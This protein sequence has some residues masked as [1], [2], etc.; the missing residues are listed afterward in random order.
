MVPDL[1]GRI[2]RANAEHHLAATPDTCV[3][4]YIDRDTPAVLEVESG[5]IIEIEAVTHHAGDA[6]DLLMDDGIRAIWSGIADVDRGPGVH[7]MTGPIAVRGARPGDTLLVRI[8]DMWPRLPYG[9][10][11]AANWGLLYNEFAKER[12]TIYGLVDDDSVASG[13][14]GSVAEPM[15]GYDF[16]TRPL[17]DIPGVVTPPDPASRQP[18]SR[19]VRVPVRPHFGVMGVAPAEPGRHSSIPPG[20]FG[21]NVDNWRIGTGTTVCYPV[22]AE[23]AM[24]YVGDPHFAQGDGEIC[25]TAI[26]ASLTARI[27]VWVEPELG[28]TSP[29]LETADAWCTH[30]FGA[31]LDEAMRMAAK[32]MLWW[33]QTHLQLSADDAYSLASI[34]MD[35]GVTQ[36]VDATLGCHALLGRGIF[37]P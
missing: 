33:M 18:F 9:S 3:W 36:V 8:L 26:E 21:G 31:D 4:G 32:Q 6:P 12:I 14:F 35:L 7:V 16:T 37:G 22:F 15:F 11:C 29:M 24:L 2:G 27:Q 25:G 23:G 28:V 30:G 10:N 5:D 1:T 17:Y 34:A 19:A 13:R 20:V